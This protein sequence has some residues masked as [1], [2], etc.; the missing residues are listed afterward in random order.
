[1]KINSPTEVILTFLA[2]QQSANEEPIME[3]QI[4]L[5]EKGFRMG[6]KLYTKRDDLYER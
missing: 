4:K 6:K 2:S 5:L 3:R 1:V